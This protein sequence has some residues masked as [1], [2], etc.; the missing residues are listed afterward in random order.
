MRPLLRNFGLIG[1]AAGTLFAQ[2]AS[3]PQNTSVAQNASFQS[4]LY[5]VLERANCPACHNADGVASA[6]RIHFPETGASPT[7]IEAFGNSLVALVDRE[8]PELSL[9]LR[10]PTARVPHT[11]G[12]RI[13]PGSPEEAV[14]LAWID[15][16][17]HLSGD[18]LVYRASLSGTGRSWPTKAGGV[19]LPRMPG[20]PPG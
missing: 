8:H 15:H 5:P 11:G 1:L 19:A 16:L 13:K 17:S 12:E 6:T 4:G 7:K 20:T 14:L 3:F 2:N 10:K 9:L 18:A